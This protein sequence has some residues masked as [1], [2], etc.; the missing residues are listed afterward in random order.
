MTWLAVELARTNWKP[1]GNVGWLAGVE[2][3]NTTYCLSQTSPGHNDAIPWKRFPDYWTFEESLV[4]FL[5]TLITRFMGPTWGP[6]GTDWSQV[7]PML[8]PWTLLSG[9]GPILR[10]GTQWCSRHIKVRGSPAPSVAKVI[11]RYI[12]C[13]L[14]IENTYGYTQNSTL[15]QQ[16]RYRMRFFFV[17]NLSFIRF[18]DVPVLVPNGSVCKVGHH[19][20]PYELQSRFIKHYKWI[21]VNKPLKMSIH[22]RHIWGHV[23]QKQVWK[24]GSSNYNPQILWGVLICPCPGYPRL[25]HNSLYKQCD[26]ERDIGE[27]AC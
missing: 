7:G 16:Q 11:W 20:T 9:K 1:T 15:V 3:I 13:H 25:E 17:F 23:Y 21:V 8:A 10:F 24:T 2:S 27:L 19:D 14:L 26:T 18:Y 12:Y 4:D 22:G 6:S 5:T